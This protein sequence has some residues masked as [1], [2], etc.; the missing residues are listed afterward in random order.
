MNTKTSESQDIQWQIILF[1]TKAIFLHLL[2]CYSLSLLVHISQ[3]LFY[4]S[5]LGKQMEVS[6]LCSLIQ[7]TVSKIS[8]L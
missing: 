8:F 2:L 5:V 6:D 7:T 1:V 4:T 3:G